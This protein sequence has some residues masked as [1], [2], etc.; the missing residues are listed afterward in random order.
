MGD[1]HTP[2]VQHKITTSTEL[3][4]NS[5]HIL[6]VLEDLLIVPIHGTLILSNRLENRVPDITEHTIARKLG[7]LCIRI[8]TT[9]TTK[10][11]AIYISNFLKTRLRWCGDMYLNQ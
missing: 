8:L 6:Q 11:V 10:I 7:C 1:G 4:I 3:A 2:N 5:A 9:W